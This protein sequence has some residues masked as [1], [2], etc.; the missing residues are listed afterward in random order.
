MQLRFTLYRVVDPDAM[1]PI[2]R[3]TSVTDAANCDITEHFQTF[4]LERKLP[5]SSETEIEAAA[6]AYGRAN[7]Q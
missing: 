7:F 5:L 6:F 1:P 2:T 3:V 4:C